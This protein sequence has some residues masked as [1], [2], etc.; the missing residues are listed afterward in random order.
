MTRKFLQELE[1]SKETIDKI[2]SA[3]GEGVERHK[4]INKELHKE[5]AKAAESL[6]GNEWKLKYEAELE[7][8]KATKE[9]HA[10]RE[11]AETIDVLVSKALKA[12]GMNEALI[13]KALKLYDRSVA[14]FKD[15]KLVNELSVLESFKAEWGDFFGKVKEKGAAVGIPGASNVQKN[16]WANAHRNLS[17]Q[18]RIYRENPALAMQMAKA[19][20]VLVR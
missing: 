1:L 11:E 9:D 8:H 4:A 18:T 17:E 3:H 12:A 14:D 5:L 15:G 13:P 6:S 19:A 16:P 20:G 10:A 2:M 7:A